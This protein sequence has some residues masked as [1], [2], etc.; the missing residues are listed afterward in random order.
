MARDLFISYRRDPDAGMALAL[1]AHLAQAFSETS[2]FMDVEDGIP[3]GEDFVQIL[4]QRVRECR[5]MLVLIG[6]N[7]LN[8]QD[9]AG[10]RRLDDP[11]DFVRIEVES[12]LRLGKLVIPVL[13]N[14]ADMPT[15]TALPDSLKPLARHQAVWISSKRLRADADGLVQKIRRA[16]D[17]DQA[18]APPVRPL[19]EK[20]APSSKAL[21]MP[22]PRQLALLGVGA[23][24]L[25]VILSVVVLV[26]PRKFAPTPT[27]QTAQPVTPMA[28]Q[29]LGSADLTKGAEYALVVGISQ[30]K[31]P[32]LQLNLA[33]KD[34]RDFASSLANQNGGI[35]SQVNVR[36]LLNSNA[37]AGAIKDGLA[38]LSHQVTTQD[39]GILYLNGH[40]IVDA[41]GHYYFLAVDSDIQHLSASAVAD[42]D[43]KAEFAAVAGKGVL[44]ADTSQTNLPVNLKTF[45][46]ALVH[47]DPNI[48]VFSATTGPEVSIE[49][50]SWGNGA[51][52]KALVEGFGLPGEPG[53]AA[54]VDSPAI[55]V[56]M[57]DTYVGGRVKALTYNKQTPFMI[58]NPSV[59]DFPVAKAR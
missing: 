25:I 58:R 3:P 20:V 9:S 10:R 5:V 59:S 32:N 15:A 22:P 38:W 46:S 2:I 42:S 34:A 30:Y 17:Q 35:Y 28:S 43:I 53:R 44:F 19:A 11:D 36:F 57:L 41:A 18:A 21:K 27:P 50:P 45:L 49:N 4:E 47:D 12:G 52:T 29:T 6:E 13:I 26:L 33:A 24:L 40:G 37:T 39:L 7:W 54:V 48:A 14:N 31:D 8:A 51:F 1:H 23:L 56:G 55:T 16:L